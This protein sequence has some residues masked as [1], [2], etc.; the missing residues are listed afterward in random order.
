MRER[1]ED[2]FEAWA[3]IVTRWRWAVVV[4]SLITTAVAATQLSYITVD[5]SN[6]SY[7]LENDP[8]RLAYDDLREQF[9][10]DQVMMISLE[11][12]NVFDAA[13]LEYLSEF[14]TALE[15]DVPNVERVT[16]LIN[17][18]SVEGR[19]D[20]LIVGDLL[21]EMPTTQTEFDALRARVLASPTYRNNVISEDGKITTIVV[22]TDTY[23][24]GGEEFDALAGFDDVALEKTPGGADERVFLTPEENAQTV[25][26]AK[27]VIA[28]FDRD[29]VVIHQAGTLMVT[30]EVT[31]AMVA[32][33]P[34]FFGGSLVVIAIALWV[35]FRRLAPC[36]VALFVVTLSVVATMGSVGALRH[37]FSIITQILPSFMLSVGVGYS[38]HLFA[39]YFQRL[40]D[41]DTHEAALAGALRHSG[42]PIMMTA[43]TTV[44][45][46]ASF[47]AATMPPLRDF[48]VAAI[49]GVVWTLVFNLSLLPALVSLFPMRGRSVGSGSVAATRALLAIGTTASRHPW[50][51][52]VGTASLA[53][54]SAYSASFSNF[55]N[56]PIEYLEPTSPFRISHNYIDE[57]FNGSSTIEMYLETSGENGLY[58]PSVMNRLERLD[59]YMAEFELE[60]YRIGETTSV[61]D[62][63]K[64]T[65]QAL[66]GNDPAFYAVPQQRALIAQELLLFENSGSDD[67]ERVVD[68]QF[69]KARYSARIKF[70]DGN[71]LAR[72]LRR[73][74]AEVPAILEPEVSFVI[75]GAISLIARTVDATSDSLVRTYGLALALITPL[76]ILLIGSLRSGL[77]SM[78]PNLLPILFTVGMMPLLGTPL[79]IFTMMVGCIAIGLA[80]DDTL[81]FIHGFR[82]CYAEHGDPHRAIEETLN[83]TGRA[84]LFTSIVL[85]AGFL[86]LTFSSMANLRALGGLTAL[87]ISAAFILDIIVT[88]ALLVLVTPK[89]SDRQGAA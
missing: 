57:R 52:V 2:G 28:R 58:E 10:R 35:L 3:G 75:T 13:F 48:G 24:T 33:L 44:A 11:P 23:S 65:H 59:A 64:E 83:T 34:M 77:V 41:G 67:L 84:L 70:V 26:V 31:Q 8:A 5:T 56:N 18:R 36:A 37:S 38:V 51:V 55:S 54:A 1:F 53:L 12:P 61:L 19:G 9:G 25:E 88:P 66:N 22:E 82:A 68:P 80:V 85:S 29:D 39:I 71:L 42:P 30:Y 40:D 76:M 74:D 4:L 72:V 16:S 45:G 21:E 7:L 78:V 60:G 14:H 81:H 49:L 63:T 89:R 32:E 47:L 50:T 86:V 87:S 17:I 46:L 73:L 69:Q 6:E 15:D 62:I 20:D 27:E 79:D 43:L